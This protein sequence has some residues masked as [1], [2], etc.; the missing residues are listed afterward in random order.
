LKKY[1]F[2]YTDIKPI[3]EADFAGTEAKLRVNADPSYKEESGVAHDALRDQII[4]TLAKKGH[5][6]IQPILTNPDYKRGSNLR[7]KEWTVRIAGLDE[8]PA[9][10][11]LDDLQNTMRKAPIF[12]L[13]STIGGRVSGDMQIKALEA[14]V[15]SL[16]AMILYLW[17]RFAKPA[18]GIAA[19]VALIHDV[20]I[21]IGALAI[22]E[23][24]V[25]AVPTLASALRIDAFQINLT[26]VA[27]L[28]TII[29]FSVNDTI[30]TFDRLREIKGKSPNLTAKMVNDAVNQT[31][32]R[33]ILTVFTVF[34]VVVILYFFGG[35]GVH[36][37][38]FAFLVGI[39]TGTY[40]SV[41]VA[42]PVVL[43]LSGVSAAPIK[44]V[45]PQNVRGMQPA[46]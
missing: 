32:S 2:E 18:Y 7:F 44:E 15:I 28:L 19:G 29:G 22:S 31:L 10:E 3:K 6:G 16:V 38:A 43:W 14:I 27:A 40:S 20:L 17:L 12:P 39:V 34:I 4:G 21:T 30:V 35:E 24:I 46:R 25:Q 45:P 41:Y 13:A 23:Y 42:S 37:F 9:R 33:T 11:V 8:P 26:I 1:A 5:T 36:S